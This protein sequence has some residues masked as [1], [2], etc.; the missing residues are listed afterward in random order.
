M[1][2]IAKKIMD[3]T[4]PTT[5]MFKGK[6]ENICQAELTLSFCLVCLC[7]FLSTFIIYLTHCKENS[8]S[9]TTYFS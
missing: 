6:E 5:S 2:S 1:T 7:V 8:P 4:Y 9:F 3:L